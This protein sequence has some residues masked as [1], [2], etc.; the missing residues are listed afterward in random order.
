M[1][2][3]LAFLAVTIG[4][5]FTA[6]AANA[7]NLTNQQLDNLGIASVATAANMFSAIKSQN[8]KKTNHQVALQVSK[9]LIDEAAKLIKKESPEISDAEFYAIP[10]PVEGKPSTVTA[11]YVLTTAAMVNLLDISGKLPAKPL[12]N[13]EIQGY[14]EKLARDPKFDLSRDMIATVIK[15]YAY[16]AHILLSN[17]FAGKQ[18]DKQFKTAITKVTLPL[19]TVLDG[20]KPI[21]SLSGLPAGGSQVFATNM[22]GGRYKDTSNGKTVTLPGWGGKGKESVGAQTYRSFWAQVGAVIPK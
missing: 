3:A 4:T 15:A 14:I 10:L 7:Q 18:T 22:I 19:Q 13:V 20:K 5:A 2:P 6:P 9:M 12:K 8:P 21:S 17:R 16:P 1:K 11:N